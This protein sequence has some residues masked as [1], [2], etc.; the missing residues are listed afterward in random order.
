MQSDDDDNNDNND[1]NHD[2]NNNN[3]NHNINNSDNNDDDYD[4]DD[5]DDD[6]QMIVIMIR[7]RQVTC[8]KAKEPMTMLKNVASTLP[9]V[10]H[11]LVLDFRKQPLSISSATSFPPYLMMMIMILIMIIMIMI[12]L[13]TKILTHT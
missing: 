10:I 2:N 12:I 8:P 13:R 1:D 3:D 7:Y 6:D 9:P 4:D 5:D 11:S